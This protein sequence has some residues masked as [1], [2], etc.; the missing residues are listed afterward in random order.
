MQLFNYKQ[1]IDL[2]VLNDYYQSLRSSDFNFIPESCTA[3]L[4]NGLGMKYKTDSGGVRLFA[5]VDSN[6]ALSF[7]PAEQSFKLVFLMQLAN[8]SF[9]NFSNL[10]LEQNGQFIYYFSNKAENK[11]EVFSL[12]SDRLLLNQNEHTSLADQLKVCGGNYR[13]SL[14]GDDGAKTAN[15]IFADRDVVMETQELNPVD[16]HY[17]FQF[18]M[19]DFPPGGYRLEVDGGEL[20]S[21]YYAPAF[22]SGSYFGVLEIFAE[23][24]EDYRWYTDDDEVSKKTYTIAFEH[25]KTLWRYKV[26]NRNGLEFDDPGVKEQEN[27]W[28]FTHTGNS[29]FVS[30]SPMPLKE[31]PIKG[32]ALRSDQNDAAS[33]LITDLPNPGPALIKPDPANPATIYSDIYVYL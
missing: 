4:L 23:V 30:N 26:I 17:N 33:V 9:M 8:P 14:A 1:I 19:D 5:S 6:G 2:Q 32:I 18:K 21:F 7:P 15:L 12:G 11:R 10:P 29:I 22:R 31:V 24:N 27:P 16:E 28:D 13:Y 25:R 20:E 3:K